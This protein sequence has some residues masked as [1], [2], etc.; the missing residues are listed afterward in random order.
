VNTAG[1]VIKLSLGQKIRVTVALASVVVTFAML[2]V[3]ETYRT[4][5]VPKLNGD[6]L[7]QV[8]IKSE[9]LRPQD[10]EV[11]RHLPGVA[12]AA[13]VLTTGVEAPDTK[14][15]IYVYAVDPEALMEVFPSLVPD[16]EVAKSW[17]HDQVGAMVDNHV[18]ARYGWK[19]GQHLTLH[20]EDSPKV[21]EIN[22]HGIY[23]LPETFKGLLVQFPYISA[24]L[25]F[26][27]PNVLVRVHDE[28]S[29]EQISS[30]IDGL[31]RNTPRETTTSAQNHYGK[32]RRRIADRTTE[33]LGAI[34]AISF[35][36][37]LLVTANVLSH[38]VRERVPQLAT[39]RVIG[40]TPGK[41][42]VF[43]VLEASLLVVLGAGIGVC[44]GYGFIA[45]SAGE[46]QGISRPSPWHILGVTSLF[47]GS[48]IAV[49]AVSP[50]LSV[51]RVRPARAIQ[52]L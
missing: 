38:G 19:A 47:A 48:A 49:T 31:F 13:G 9:P 27:F 11:I 6:D 42:V 12:A 24:V 4:G 41:L 14:A 7:L 1:L 2:S 16:P 39:L 29:S 18:A 35:V 44:L 23:S 51:L 30:A 28:S 40:F 26:G 46:F 43:I 45:S 32:Q 15:R 10:I 36:T 17:S 37:M 22:V 3:L 20:F 52:N 25:S 50:V 8:N 33:S 5:V 21:I 34:M